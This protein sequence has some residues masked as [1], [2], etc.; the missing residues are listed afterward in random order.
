MTIT[1]ND[2]GW[3]WCWR[4]PTK[5]FLSAQIVEK[6]CWI[7]QVFLNVFVFCKTPQTHCINVCNVIVKLTRFPCELT[8]VQH[9][10]FRHLLKCLWLGLWPF[11]CIDSVINDHILNRTLLKHKPFAYLVCCVLLCKYCVHSI[12]PQIAYWML[13]IITHDLYVIGQRIKFC[14]EWYINHR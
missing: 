7:Q 10:S 6:Y 4:L 5:F 13:K 1:Y 8:S 9:F 11:L 3:S 2:S 14:I 12:A